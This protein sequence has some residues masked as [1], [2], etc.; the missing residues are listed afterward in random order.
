MPFKRK[1]YEVLKWLYMVENW[2]LIL[3]MCS[4]CC[5]YHQFDI[6]VGH[7]PNAMLLALAIDGSGVLFIW[8]TDYR[9][10]TVYVG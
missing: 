1:D 4:I 8:C 3:A 6:A 5:E 9:F 10:H 2:T 7:I